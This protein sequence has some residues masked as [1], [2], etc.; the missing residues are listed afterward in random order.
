MNF[1]IVEDDEY[2]SSF[3][4][5]NLSKYGKPFIS[6][7]FENAKNLLE[8]YH[9]DCAILDLK[10]GNEVIGPKI[11]KLA[12]ERG[13]GHVIA[14]TH[15]E[16]DEELVREAY[17][18]GV[19]DFVKKSN[20]RT[21]LEFFIKKVVNSRDLKKNVARLTKT[22][23]ITKDLDLIKSLEEVCDTYAPLEP[24]FIGGETGVGKTQ[25]GKCLKQLLGLKGELVELNCAGLNDE[26]LKSELFGHEKGSFT[27]ADKQKIGKIELAH[28]GILFLDEVGDMPLATQE[29]LLKVIDEK[30]FTRVGGLTKIKSNFLLVTATLK[31]LEELVQ[32]GR[33]RPDFYNRIKGKTI[34]IKPLRER[35]QDLKLLMEHFLNSA[36]RSVYLDKEA[37]DALLNYSWPGN[38]RELQKTIFRLS[39][40]KHGIV[41]KKHLDR[42]IIENVNPLSNKGSGLLTPDH[43]SFLKEHKSL[44]AF[45]DKITADFYQ[46]ALAE[47]GGNK[48]KIMSEYQIVKS[49][50]HRHLNA[51]KQEV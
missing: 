18:S 15:F 45:L 25:L 30:E 20:L 40:T 46:F 41:Q 16:N 3:L 13:I 8:S 32:S 9:F 50:L 5:Q 38:I 19:D 17:E 29:K 24:I 48:S 12:K 2:F 14:V 43:I 26:I 23:Y 10:L 35:K 11:A 27:G 28:E 37:K 34:F 44:S 49:T 36:P 47:T 31:N 39:D 51:I 21:H 42:N 22:A 1:L 7:S 4:A 6:N 33:I